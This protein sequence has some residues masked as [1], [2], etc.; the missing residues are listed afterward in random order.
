MNKLTGISEDGALV[1]G[2]MLLRDVKITDASI[3]LSIDSSCEVSNGKDARICSSGVCV[4][5]DGVSSVSFIE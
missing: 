3:G 2:V 1:G 5:I 4:C